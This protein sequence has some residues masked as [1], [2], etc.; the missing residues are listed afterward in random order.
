MKIS[1]RKYI[2]NTLVVA[3]AVAIATTLSLGQAAAGEQ[4]LDGPKKD[5]NS[6]S[7]QTEKA[8]RPYEKLIAHGAGTVE[9]FPTSSSVDAMK[10]A[11]QNGF[12][13]IELDLEFSS[14]GKI[15]M[16]H[17]WDRT[18]TTYLGRKF[19]KPLSLREFNN[20]LI[21]GRF[22]ALTFD[23]LTKILDENPQVQIITDTKEDNVKLL[24]K[25]AETYPQYIKRIIPQIYDYNEFDSV[26]ALGYED[27]IFTLYMQNTINYSKLLNFVQ[28]KGVYAVTIDKNY[29]IKGLP[30][31]LSR[32]GVTVYTHP[33]DTIEE[34]QE[35]FAKGAYGVYSSDLIPAEVAGWGADYYLTQ[36]D[37]KGAPIKLTDMELP[38]SQLRE[39][40][41]HGNLTDKALSYKLDG[42][43][44]ETQLAELEDSPSQGHQLTIELWDTKS[45]AAAKAP[46]PFY[47]MTY[48]VTKNKGQLRV[49]DTKYDYRLKELKELPKLKDV[50]AEADKNNKDVQVRELLAQAFI[51]KA[52]NYYYYN[53]GQNGSYWVGDELLAAQRS[54]SGNVIVPLAETLSQL[55]ADSVTMD[56]AKYVYM[57]MNGQKTISQVYGNYL[58]R[59]VANSKL[60]VPISLYR[61]KT[62]GGGE[63]IAQVSGRTYIEENGLLILL[64]EDCRISSKQAE[65]LIEMADLLYKD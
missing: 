9:G 62:M 53:E 65:K 43:D 27:I 55:G 10:L 46:Q 50:L 22:E 8:L 1:L 49:L 29:W 26:A 18:V 37:S 58:H 35:Q 2:K 51:A 3:V 17:D 56:K 42:Q 31:K 12:K 59:G 61:E 38:D 45:K 28:D 20:Q 57:V 21:Y 48:T 7:S 6:E 30:E 64:P 34:A 24:T 19:D 47:T 13:W 15:I 14:D 40:P 44:L 52:G 60:S 23:K 41:I 4:Q 32:D 16:L 36:E 11:I 25:I 39:I 63:L 5:S 54:T 33:V